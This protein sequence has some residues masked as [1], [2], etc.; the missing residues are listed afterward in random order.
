MNPKVERMLQAMAVIL[1]DEK[2]ELIVALNNVVNDD[3]DGY[4]LAEYRDGIMESIPHH[5]AGP[6]KDRI[7]TG[8]LTGFHLLRKLF[9]W[10]AVRIEQDKKSSAP[11]LA[12]LHEIFVD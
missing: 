9:G 11:L 4:R 5:E 1:K 2:I 6:Y 8:I 3:R 7:D 10:C 12:D